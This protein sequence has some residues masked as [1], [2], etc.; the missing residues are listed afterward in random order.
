M[1]LDHRVSFLRGIDDLEQDLNVVTECDWVSGCYLLARTSAL[2]G[3]EWFLTPDF[4]MYNDDNDLCLRLRRLGWKIACFPESV[5]HIGGGNAD[6]L[7]ALSE[8]GRQV[9]SLAI[10]S[11]YL[12]YRRNYGTA[13]VLSQYFWRLVF[14]LAQV[15]KRVF[16]LR[17][18]IAISDELRFAAVETRILVTTRLGRTPLH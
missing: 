11:T 3:L 15:T 2:D 13:R 4:F 10:E 12:Y 6:K 14:R 18:D 9:D 5:V 17:P 8:G 1:G 16:R 7:G